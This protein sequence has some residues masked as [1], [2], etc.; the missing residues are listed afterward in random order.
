MSQ[1][2]KIFIINLKNEFGR[3]K[4]I[5]NELKKLNLKFEIFYAKKGS[6]LSKKEIA[7]YS[8]KEAFK[9][10]N[11]DLSLDEISCA[12]SHIKIYKKIVESKYR[13]SLILEDDV[14]INKN[15]LSIFKN[16]N[17]FPKNWELINFY[18]DARKKSIGKKIYKNYQ[19][20]RF[21]ERANRTCSYLIKMRTAKKF[22][23]FA[24]PIRFPADGL[25][26]RNDLTNIHS[27]GLKPDIIQIKDFPTTIKN[28]NSLLGKYKFTSWIRKIF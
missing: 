9:N 12:L 27:Y 8:K 5:V 26:G 25:T 16:L 14:V 20:V 23:K 24:L 4:H 17:K 13:L 6:G 21:N 10:E 7:L 2:I 18:T 15:L 3:R 1:S 19:C 22:I 28:R 11:R